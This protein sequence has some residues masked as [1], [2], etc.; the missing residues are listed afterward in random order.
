MPP[1][2]WKGARWPNSG[3]VM[4]TSSEAGSATEPRRVKRLTRLWGFGS[5]AV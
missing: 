3:K 5:L 2:M 4:I 1:P